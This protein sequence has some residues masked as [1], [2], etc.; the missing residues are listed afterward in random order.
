MLLDWRVRFYDWL[1]L[2]GWLLRHRFGLRN[3][4]RSWLC[5]MEL[6]FMGLDV[7]NVIETTTGFTLLA[8]SFAVEFMKH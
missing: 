4:L 1:G 5:F 6:F 2:Y 7:I 3:Y 8:I